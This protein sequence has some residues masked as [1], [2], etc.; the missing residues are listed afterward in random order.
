MPE[1]DLDPAAEAGQV[2]VGGARGDDD[3]LVTT[4][5]AEHAALP[6]GGLEPAGDLLEQFVAGRVA[7]GVVDTLEAVEVAEEHAEV[8]GDLLG[9]EHQAAAVEQ[10]GELVARGL[11]LVGLLEPLELVHEDGV[12]ETDPRLGDEQV[13]RLDAAGD[14]LG[15]AGDAGGEGV[16]VAAGDL[17]LAG[18]Q[19]GLVLLVVVGRGRR[20]RRP[21][22]P[23]VPTP[24][25]RCR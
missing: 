24:C 10:A 23:V 13:E 1:V 18:E 6:H 25:R 19:D 3:E 20:R 5:A 7:E 2:L 14:L 16:R 15:R 8:A 17:E 21:R 22:R 12:G 9:G 11:V 4:H